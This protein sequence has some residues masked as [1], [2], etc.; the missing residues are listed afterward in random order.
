MSDEIKEI[1]NYFNKYVDDKYETYTVVDNHTNNLRILLDYITN[2]QEENERLRQQNLSLIEYR[3]SIIDENYD[4]REKAIDYKSRI[5]KAL[6]YIIVELLDSNLEYHKNNYACISGSDLPSDCIV[7]I[8]DIL[9]D[10][11]GGEN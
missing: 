7:K 3:D 1:L 11:E 6:K 4:N 2:L 9:N 10:N 8:V 5:D